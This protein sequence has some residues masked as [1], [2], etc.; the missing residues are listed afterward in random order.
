M[1]LT[2]AGIFLALRNITIF[3]SCLTLAK[4]RLVLA[5]AYALINKF[6]VHTLVIV[7]YLRI[8]EELEIHILQNDLIVYR[9]LPAGRLG[10]ETLHFNLIIITH[11]H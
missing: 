10:V 8:V 11:V 2:V 1:F 6:S 3:R 4:C 9:F 7:L 5:L